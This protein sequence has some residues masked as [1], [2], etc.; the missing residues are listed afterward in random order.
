MY[1][2]WGAEFPHEIPHSLLIEGAVHHF[3]MLR[4]LSGGDCQSLAGWEWNPAWSSS[5]GEFC[6]LYALQMTNGVCLVQG[7]G[8]AAGT[9]NI[10]H[11][12]YY[13]V[14]CENGSVMV[15]RDHVVRVGS[16]AVRACAPRKSFPRRRPTRSTSPS[17]ISS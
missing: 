12:E 6:N 2:S 11:D 17:S 13:R 4:N 9:Q 8:T 1:G 5:K 7:A 14:E 3:D 15:D 10:W 16:A